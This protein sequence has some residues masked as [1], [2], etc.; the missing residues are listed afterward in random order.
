[1]VTKRERGQSPPGPTS[2]SVGWVLSQPS[3]AKHTLVLRQP[4]QAE[5]LITPCTRRGGGL[6]Q[7]RTALPFIE[8]VWKATLAGFWS[9]LGPKLG[10]SQLLPVRWRP[11][12]CRMAEPW[13]KNARIQEMIYHCLCHTW[14]FISS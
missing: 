8:T 1:M 9:Y 13:D 6:C 7:H 11:W 10:H 2:P 4:W 14:P 3:A 5:I 12:C